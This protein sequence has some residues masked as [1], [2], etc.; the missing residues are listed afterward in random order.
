[1]GIESQVHPTFHFL[2]HFTM[3]QIVKTTAILAATLLLFSCLATRVER[4]STTPLQPKSLKG[5]VALKESPPAKDSTEYELIIFDQGF[6]FWLNSQVHSKH[7]YTNEYMQNINNQYVIEWNRRYAMG[8]PRVL[9]YLDYNIF[10]NYGLEF[11]YKL[12]M[13]FRY[14]EES[15]KV[16]LLP[17]RSRK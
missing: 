4:G 2:L 15:N 3:K 16:K 7:L 17:Y 11:N 9:S 1:M 14:F 10:N 12:F 13:Y 5:R 8:D 6:D